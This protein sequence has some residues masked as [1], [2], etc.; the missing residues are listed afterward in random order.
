MPP[1]ERIRTGGP[2]PPHGDG[3]EGR[4]KP[5]LS[6]ARPRRRRF[7][8]TPLIA[9]RSPANRSGGSLF[10]HLRYIAI[11]GFPFQTVFGSSKPVQLDRIS[12]HSWLI[13]I[14][15]GA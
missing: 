11:G 5:P 3:E 13:C 15:S 8:D 6:S 9:Q 4:Q 12:F 7:C 14:W 10:C 2:R 1:A